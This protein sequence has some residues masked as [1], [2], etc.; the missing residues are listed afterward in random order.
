M[1]V[2][3]NRLAERRVNRLQLDSFNEKLRKYGRRAAS[4][5]PMSPGMR[6]LK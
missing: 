6:P 1:P 3:G 4:S 5:V 2:N